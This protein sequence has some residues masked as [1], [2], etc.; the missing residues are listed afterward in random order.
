M[1]DVYSIEVDGLWIG[2][3][4]RKPYRING[5]EGKAHLADW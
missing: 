4:E 2:K 1:M 5:N 3:R